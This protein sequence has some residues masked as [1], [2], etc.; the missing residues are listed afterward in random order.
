MAAGRCAV[1]RVAHG[2]AEALAAFDGGGDH[3][4]TERGRNNI[5]TSPTLRP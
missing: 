5:L 1:A 4:A 3:L 2:D